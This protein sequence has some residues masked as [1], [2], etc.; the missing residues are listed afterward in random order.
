MKFRT[1]FVTNSSTSCFIAFH[2]KNRR[3]F[4]ALTALGISFRGVE[5]G[6]FTNGM[7]IELPSGATDVIEYDD[8]N[9]EMFPGAFRSDSVS[10]WLVSQLIS[11]DPEWEDDDDE[12]ED[13][14]DELEDDD[15]FDD[16]EARKFEFQKELIGLLNK[17]DIT[18]LDLE[19]AEE[20]PWESILTGLEKAFGAMDEKIEE[21]KLEYIHDFEGEIDAEYAEIK[22]G[23]RMEFFYGD[24]E[25]VKTESCKGRTFVVTGELEHYQ[26]RDDLAEFLEKSGGTLADTVSEN[27]DYLIC[28][29]IASKAPEMERAKEFGIAVLSETAFIRRFRDPNFKDLLAQTVCGWDRIRRRTLAWKRFWEEDRGIEGILS[30][31]MED[32]A[33]PIEM[34]VW[35]N[36][37]WVRGG[38]K[39]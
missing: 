38:K 15:D 12:L 18:H 31:V 25:E 35:K 34:K 2:V 13:D 9:W 32:G 4:E 39:H 19:A 3:L 7:E 26:S 28:S 24:D 5:D 30:A 33:G 29:D 23:K 36:G 22:D 17:A 11:R 27:T 6:E 1:D 20:W 14:D 21:A 8:D 10:A 37:K 16:E